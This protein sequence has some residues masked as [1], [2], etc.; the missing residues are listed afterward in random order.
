MRAQH[1]GLVRAAHLLTGQDAAAQDLVQETLVQVLVHWSKVAGAD[2]PAAYLRRTM[3]NTFLSGRRR[4][5]HRE[6][7]HAEP[8][9]AVSTDMTSG[10]DDRDL[11]A[12]ALLAL[13]ARQRAALVLRYDDDQTE[14]QTAI[15]LGCAV[16]TEKSLTSRGLAGLRLQLQG[17]EP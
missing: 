9:G 17:V 15:A 13:P 6:H 12:R 5:W 1:A 14:A 2:E 10:V 16:G 7:P 8:P 4:R 3:V 11:L